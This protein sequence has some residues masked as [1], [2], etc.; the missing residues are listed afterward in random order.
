MAPA[1]TCAV[2]QRWMSEREPELG[3]GVVLR[4]DASRVEIAFPATGEKRLYAAGTP[5]LRRVQFRVGDSVGDRAGAVLLVEKVEEAAGVLTYAGQGRSLREDE[6]SDLTN[7]RSPEERLLAGQ[8]EPGEVFNLRFRALQ[9]QAKF[10]QSEVRGFLGA[11]VELIPHQLYILQE[12]SS[13][14]IARVLLADDVGLGKTIEACLILQRLLAIGKVRR[15]LI[16]VPESLTHQWF[17]ELLRRFNLWFSIYDEERCLAC[18]G[19]DPGKNPFHAAQLVLA[20]ISFLAGDLRRR[21]QLVAAGWDLVVID[22]AHHLDWTPETVSPNYAL[23]EA[24]AA[25]SPHLLLLTATPT[26]LGLAAHFA[27]LRLLDPNRYADYGRFLQEAENFGPVAEIAEKIVEAQPLQ[28]RDRETLQRIFDRDPARL[29]QH[30]EALAEGRPG[31]RETLIR[32]LLDQYGPGRVVLRNTRAAMGGFP[33]RKFCPAPVPQNN[34]SQLARSARELRAEE[35]GE[36]AS[37]RY[38]FKEDPRIDWLAGLLQEHRP[39]KVLLIC[40]SSRK[41]M[42]IDSALQTRLS[43]KTGLFHE[44]LPLVQRDRNAAWFAEPD[45]AQLLLCS[46]IGSEGRNFQFAH[47]LVLFDLPLN[48]GLLEQRIG[49]LDRIGQT[50][51]IR[52]HVPFL[53]GSAE[54]FVLDWY[55]RGLDAIE[56]PLQS[57]DEYERRFKAR[58]LAA[59]LGDADGREELIAETARFRAELTVKLQQG[60]DRLLELNSFNRPAAQGLIARIRGVDADPFLRNFLVALL[61][62]FGVRIKEHEKGDV[63]LDPSHAYVEAFPSIP[64]RGM[65]ATFDRP[66]ALVREDLHFLSPD[67]SLVRDAIDLLLAA[68]AG[69]VAFG[70]LR[71]D[72]PNLLLEA[73]FVLEAVADSRWQVDQFLAP[74]PVRVVIDLRG[75]DLAAEWPAPALAAAVTDAPFEH[76]RDLPGFNAEVLKM[77]VDRAMAKAEEQARSLKQTALAKANGL[78]L[79]E[80]QRLVDLRKVNDHVRPEEVEFVREQLERILAAIGHGRLRLEALRLIAQQ[81]GGI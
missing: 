43:V 78:L 77:L 3:L 31:A 13:R 56:T 41:A 42:A 63:F 66:R 40:K 39:A 55:Q 57:G 20:S 23:A 38:A 75:R 54:E 14:P 46:E 32:T 67:H 35:A 34:L 29:R 50:Q 21:D 48:P 64:R 79:A 72:A 74:T 76:F 25:V 2:G 37:L 44:G 45:G 65:L 9:A 16:L 53:Q 36:G 6:V 59:A 18:E 15:A 70:F 19:S 81:A 10:R 12:V 52:I 73:V 47:H 71:S 1:S 28:P 5:A 58:V 80:H 26:Q 8:G 27:R 49:R 24:L 22:E 60:R 51:P 61:D 30:L 11:R 7:S 33:K 62:H 4:T 17:V 69:T 68:K